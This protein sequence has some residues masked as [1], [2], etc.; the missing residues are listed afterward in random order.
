MI[1]VND[2]NLKITSLC[3]FGSRFK[4]KERKKE[5]M[6]TAFGNKNSKLTS[7]SEVKRGVR[8]WMFPTQ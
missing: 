5:R 7:K 2:T 3:L 1:C 8:K 4:K 6:N